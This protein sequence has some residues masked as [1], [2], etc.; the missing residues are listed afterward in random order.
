MHR[1]A[2]SKKQMH[3]ADYSNHRMM[4]NTSFGVRSCFDER[5]NGKDPWWTKPKKPSFV[6]SGHV[7]PPK[8][9]PGAT[10]P[11][12]SKAD[13]R[14][15]AAGSQKLD[16]STRMDAPRYLHK[17]LGS[18]K[19]DCPEVMSRA[20]TAPNLKTSR[21]VALS[22]QMDAPFFLQKPLG[23]PERFPKG[24]DQA[25]TVP[26]FKESRS[27]PLST[28]MDAPRFLQKPLGRPWST[29]RAPTAPI[30]DESRSEACPSDGIQGQEGSCANTPKEAS[31]AHTPKS[32][33]QLSRSSPVL[34]AGQQIITNPPSVQSSGRESWKVEA[35]VKDAVKKA[36]KRAGVDKQLK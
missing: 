23:R 29:S 28:Q 1:W 27:V 22:T 26:K 8:M 31:R 19:S 32:T 35:A 6:T 10:Y 24:M 17:P 21:T 25:C 5:Y 2:S 34:Q 12:P 13:S 3:L 9:D 30:L 16:F 20:P 14:L 33:M 4:S 18:A 15:A 36:C 11:K 7:E